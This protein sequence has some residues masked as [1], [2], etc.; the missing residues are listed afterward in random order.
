MKKSFL[1]GVGSLLLLASCN[2]G[3]EYYQTIS[4]SSYPL[5]II[6]NLSNETTEVSQGTYYF[7][8]SFT[9]DGNT[10]YV[11]A[12][13]VAINKDIPVNFQTSEQTYLSDMNDSYSVYGSYALFED[14]KSTSG[15][16]RNASFLLTPRFNKPA[17]FQPLS[18]LSIAFPD[19]MGNVAVARYYLG[20]NYLVHTFLPE[21]L[22]AGTT[23]T[24]YPY[25]GQNQS[26][27]TNDIYYQLSWNPVGENADPSKATLYIYNAKFSNSPEPIKVR[28]RLSDLDVK[29]D[30]N[31]ITVTGSDIVSMVLEGNG[32][33]EYNN[34]IFKNIE[35]RT[36]NED[37]TQCEIIFTVEH[38]MDMQ[39]TSMTV[40]YEGAFEGSYL[41]LPEK[42]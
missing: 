18:S 37:L 21:T 41:S 25:M 1:I 36:T 39:G 8:F 12:N 22:F 26:Y 29:C 10:G 27:Q 13:N 17:N 4:Y 34:F 14:A 15:N 6:T 19:Y 2:G 16:L 35:F 28:I 5:N 24:S 33:T 42:I 31:G 7:I 23:S 9:N 3:S 30:A 38:T 40:N 11:A 20:E 32:E